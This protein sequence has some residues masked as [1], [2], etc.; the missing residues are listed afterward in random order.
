MRMNISVDEE[1]KKEMDTIKGTNWSR[2]AQKAFR[3]YIR[4]KREY[5]F[6]YP[7]YEKMEDVPK[8]LM[9]EILKSHGYTLIDKKGG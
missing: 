5:T 9:R 4:K 1:L 7:V 2:V 6:E 3:K 8:E